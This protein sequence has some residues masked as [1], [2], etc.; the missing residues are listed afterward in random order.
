MICEIRALFRETGGLRRFIGLLALRCPTDTALTLISAAFLR[1]ALNGVM[2]GDS[3]KLAAACLFYLLESL[4]VFLYNGI[5]W[6]QYAAF[7][8]RWTARLK[9][10]VMGAIAALPL[11][12]VQARPAGDWITRMNADVN[13]AGAM[14]SGSIQLPH[15]VLAAVRILVSVWMLS[16]V[17]PM[18][19]LL[20]LL[21]LVPHLLIN[22]WAL[23]HSVT[24]ISERVQQTQ[25]QLGTDLAAMVEG[26]DAAKVFDAEKWLL[27][28]FERD[29]LALR[30]DKM[31]LHH[32]AALETGILPIFGMSGYLSI[33]AVG[34]PTIAR[35]GMAFGD[36][37]AALEY[38]GGVMIGAMMLTQSAL[39]L[40]ASLAGARRVNEVL[41]MKREA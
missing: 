41:Q 6:T 18:I 2:E 29:S 1:D 30:R 13:T 21:F 38:R 22:R 34:A 27:S 33:L 5:V 9:R 17:S 16:R 31:R 8:A 4:A 20:V 3:Q 25:G 12:E 35:G 10:A 32:R 24:G 23:Q 28:R 40:R 37:T 11:R 19:L 14:L 36:L 15:A 39:N 26:A 7:I